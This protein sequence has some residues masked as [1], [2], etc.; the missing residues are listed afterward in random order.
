[1]SYRD[2]ISAL[3]SRRDRLV[4][5]LGEARQAADELA[6]TVERVPRLEKE[7]AEVDGLLASGVVRAPP[8]L[9]NL[10]M[11]SPCKADWDGMLGNDRVRFCAQCGKSV[12]NLSD[13]ARE[14][15]EAFL[16]EVEAAPCVRFFR[17]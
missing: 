5:E 17:R 6:R 15:A 7:L 11:A 1:M 14:E 9:D 13:M 3:V 8:S 10:R 16:R 12:Y 2:S 4:A